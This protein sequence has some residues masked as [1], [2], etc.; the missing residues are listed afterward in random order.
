M[1]TS[2]KQN[3][4]IFTV[5]DMGVLTCMNNV[6]SSKHVT[7]PKTLDNGTV[8]TAIGANF[9]KGQYETLK[10]DD[11]IDI[12]IRGA[13]GRAVGIDELSKNQPLVGTEPYFLLRIQRPL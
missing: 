9:C 10:I 3:D 5:D 2:I 1:P 4:V 13:F 7:I 12:V 8:I 6:G 11:D